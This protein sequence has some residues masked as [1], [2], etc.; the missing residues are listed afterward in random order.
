MIEKTQAIVLRYYPDSNTSRVVSWL[1]AE[2]GRITTLIKG[3][4]RPKSA[5]I[6][7]Y[8]LFYTCELVYYTRPRSGVHIARECGPLKTRDGLRANWKGCAAASYMADLISRISPPDAP[9][10]ELFGLL[11]AG[12]DEVASHPASAEFLFWFELRLLEQLGLAPRLQHCLACKKPLAPGE[13]RS[14]FSYARGGILCPPCSRDAT[15]S[16]LPIAADILAILTS[17]QRA[18]NPQAARATRCS[19]R[20]LAEI[21]NLLGLFLAYHLDTPLPGRPIALDILARKPA[22]ANCA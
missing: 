12:L 18:Q 6:G 4:Q 8:D 22:S 2:Q 5:F 7:Q 19:T 21:E 10:A 14:R 17:W 16:L 15:D 3:S 13:R 20:Q 11:E 9:H 1:T